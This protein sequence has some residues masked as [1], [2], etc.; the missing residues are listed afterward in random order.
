[1]DFLRCV[2]NIPPERIALHSDVSFNISSETLNAQK[3]KDFGENYVKRNFLK[4]SDAS[5]ITE[6]STLQP[7]NNKDY[8]TLSKDISLS[9]DI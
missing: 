4:P 3:P 7:S 5:T 8:L 2:V 1:M 6:L 9:T